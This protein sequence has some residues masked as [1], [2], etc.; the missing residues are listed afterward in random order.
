MNCRKIRTKSGTQKNKI[1][2]TRLQK[3]LFWLLANKFQLSSA[4]IHKKLTSI[5]LD[6]GY[7]NIMLD[8]AYKKYKC[9]NLNYLPWSSINF[10]FLILC[11]IASEMKLKMRFAVWRDIFFVLVCQTRRIK[12][13][14]FARVAKELSQNRW[15]APRYGWY[16]FT[17]L[18]RTVHF[19]T[20]ALSH[21]KTFFSQEKQCVHT[22]K[23]TL[24][25]GGHIFC[26]GFNFSIIF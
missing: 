12:T 6:N 10:Y 13:H 4:P 17:W 14:R 22:N 26:I 11:W 2:I 16:Y 18:T 3:K 7:H 8:E 24:N 19:L 25:G 5:L 9:T 20:S 23:I 1:R 21:L 15:V